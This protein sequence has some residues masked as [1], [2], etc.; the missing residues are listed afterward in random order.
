VF[1]IAKEQLAPL[2]VARP[3]LAEMLSA[4]VAARRLGLDEALVRRAPEAVT[5]EARTL[6]RSIL[7]AMRDFFGLGRAESGA[8]RRAASE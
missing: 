5:A 7:I 1:E 2:L 6:S 3:G 4:V 8:A